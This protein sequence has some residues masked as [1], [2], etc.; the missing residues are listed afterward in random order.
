[1]S[2]NGDL[3]IGVL[4]LHTI[5]WSRSEARSFFNA[6][7]ECDLPMAIVSVRA[8]EDL[9]SGSNGVHTRGGVSAYQYAQQFLHS[10]DRG[11]VGESSLSHSG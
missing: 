11:V 4:A 2:T 5:L 1:M 7:R 6:M 10:A 3:E 9:P 8:A